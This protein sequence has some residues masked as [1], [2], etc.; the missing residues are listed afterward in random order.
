MPLAAG[1][2][3][4]QPHHRVPLSMA[5]A[6]WEGGRYRG[7][8]TAWHA[9]ENAKRC[10]RRPTFCSTFSQ[11][12]QHLAAQPVGALAI[13]PPTPGQAAASG[14]Y[15]RRCSNTRTCKPEATAHATMAAATCQTTSASKPALYR[16]RPA[17]LRPPLIG[18]PL[19]RPPRRDRGRSPAPP[20]QRPRR[21]DQLPHP[22]H[23][24]RRLRLPLHRRPHRTG[25]A[26]P[27]RSLPG[28]PGAPLIRRPGKSAGSRSPGSWSGPTS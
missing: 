28:S 2:D 3:Q 18:R 15:G 5:A 20:Q 27:R 24:S 13:R 23:H 22:S 16:H 19:R 14:R 26:I 12:R 21:G 4:H 10:C 11:M 8:R 6:A 9:R 7:I 25:D 17:L 1:K